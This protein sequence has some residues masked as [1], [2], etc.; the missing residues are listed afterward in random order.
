M[1]QE[2]LVSVTPPDPNPSDNKPLSIIEVERLTGIRQGTLRIW[3]RRYGFP[4][5]LRDAHGNR[6]YPPEQVERLKA[7]RSLML[8]GARPGRIFADAGAGLSLPA[9]PPPSAVHQEAIGLLRTYRLT[10]LHAQLLFHLMSSG[11]RDF[12][13]DLLVPL[14]DAVTEAARYGE[15]PLRFVH[16]YE[17]LAASVLHRGLSTLRTVA[18]NRPRVVLA[19][20]TGDPHVLEIMMVETV[21]T[22][23]GVDCLQLGADTPPQEIAAAAVESGAAMVAVSINAAAP[24]RNLGR[25]LA[26]LRAS[27]PAG[28]ALWI[29]GGGARQLAA[30]AGIDHIPSVGDIETAL[31]RWRAGT[32][33]PSPSSA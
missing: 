33:N 8:Q 13:V 32:A 9:R 21:L 1:R 7:A 4:Q 6:I 30:P 18:E 16:L 23:L 14:S 5:P 17:Q 31:A 20:L 29:G 10:E 3:E 12:V 27:L 28:T 26:T 25:L 19:A 22:T 15:L 2:N 24:R 11:L